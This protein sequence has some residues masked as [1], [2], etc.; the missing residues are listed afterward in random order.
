MLAEAKLDLSGLDE[1]DRA[2]IEGMLRGSRSP[3]ARAVVLAN[4][5]KEYTPKVVGRAFREF[6]ASDQPWSTRLFGG[7]LRDAA[8]Q[9]ERGDNRER[10][11]KETGH[12]DREAVDAEN[13][14]RE[15]AEIDALL[16]DFER[17]HGEEFASMQAQAAKLVPPNVRGV[18]RKA[19]EEAH[20]VKMIRVRSGGHHA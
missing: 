9:I 5:L 6:I 3:L 14:K 8:K 7:F 2:V 18:F 16:T 19:M 4:A 11:K 20:L 13:A 17:T 1:A 10:A 15:K 12:L